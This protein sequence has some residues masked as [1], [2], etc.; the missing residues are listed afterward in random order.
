MKAEL[1]SIFNQVKSDFCNLVDFKMRGNTIEITTGISTLTNHYVSVFISFDS[2]IYA[3]SDGGWIDRQY[4][5]N[6]TSS[7]DED[8]FQRVEF[9]YRNHYDIK[10]TTHKD[11]T[12]YNFKTTENVEMVSLLVH[13]VS[14]Y[15]ASVVNSQSI[16]FHEA[17]EQS[18]RTTFYKDVTGFLKDAYGSNLE[19][20]DA[21]KNYND[22]LSGIKFNAIVRLP[23]ATH[24]LMYV[25]G[26]TPQYFIKDACEATVN[27]QI[28]KKYSPKN[29]FKRTAIVNTQAGGHVPG[30]VNE[31]L[32]NLE[33]E[34]ENKLVLY[35]ND[36]DK[37]EVLRQIPRKLEV[38]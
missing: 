1:I 6:I 19:T 25:T 27:F 9:Q 10:R 3:I 22:E 38:A 18:Q 14:N 11:G 28:S 36:D 8:T 4:Y 16:A 31:Y 32:N 26:Y 5:D 23:T 30:R 29:T 12:K 24:L 33:I 21:L 34:A 7:E 13:D 37:K 2:G 17:K 15:I 20:N 35:Y